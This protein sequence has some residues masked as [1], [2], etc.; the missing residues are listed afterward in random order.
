[1]IYH[2]KK[3]LCRPRST[4]SVKSSQS[5]LQIKI[6]S[7][8]PTDSS[9]FT[10]GDECK[11]EVGYDLEHLLIM[12][13]Q[14]VPRYNL[15][16]EDLFKKTPD[17]HVDKA[18]LGTALE[19]MKTIASKINDC[20]RQTAKVRELTAIA[21]KTQGLSSLLEAHR[22][23]IRDSVITVSRKGVGKQ[24]EIDSNK[25]FYA[26]STEKMQFILFNDLLVYVPKAKMHDPIKFGQQV[27]LHLVWMTSNRVPNQFDIFVPGFQ[28]TL[29]FDEKKQM[30]ECA[31]WISDFTKTVDEH[32]KRYWKD[33]MEGEIEATKKKMTEL[34]I[35]SWVP[36]V[37]L[38][39]LN[40]EFPIRYGKYSFHDSATFQGWFSNGVAT[41]FGTYALH[42]NEYEGL[43]DDGLQSGLGRCRYYT[44]DS[45]FGHWSGGLP[46]GCGLWFEY[47]F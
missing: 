27:P 29:Q 6:S 26:S 14:R 39:D 7:T 21:S 9:H 1:M 19:K 45:Y 38:A 25:A 17:D 4:E 41:G 22:R 12:P 35:D 3:S 13:V 36:D 43:F 33:K 15:L 10:S 8:R 23:L 47:S 5:R 40:S 30:G 20:M 24:T 42:G 44:G 2:V 34:K 16:I 46:N 31:N 11:K 32:L 28:F 18:D 37:S